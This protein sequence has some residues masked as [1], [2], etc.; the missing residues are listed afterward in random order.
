MLKQKDVNVA[1]TLYS[2][3]EEVMEMVT[4]ICELFDKNNW[5]IVQIDGKVSF[6]DL[7]VLSL[8]REDSHSAMLV[9]WRPDR[10]YTN[11]RDPFCS[12]FILKPYEL[13]ILYDYVRDKIAS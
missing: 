2:P 7:D 10:R 8:E 13:R 5:T 9:H 6:D 11:Q 3:S 12:A 1:K 4:K